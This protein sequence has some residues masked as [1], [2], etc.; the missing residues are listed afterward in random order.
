MLIP[1]STEL[2]HL[3]ALQLVLNALA[4]RRIPNQGKN[5]PDAF[6]E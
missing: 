3:V 1:P 2:V 6:Y 5:R 4:I